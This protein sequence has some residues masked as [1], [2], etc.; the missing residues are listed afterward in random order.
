LLLLAVAALTL[1][2]I[3]SAIDY[4]PNVIL[5]LADDLGYGDIG[6]YGNTKYR[7]PN[8]DRLAQDGTKFT[9]FYVAQAVCTASRAALMTGC[10]PNRVGMSGALN[11]T[12]RTGLNLDEALLCSLFSQRGYA[13]A[14]YGKWHLGHQP[15][16]LPTRRGFD[17]WQGLPYS[18]DNGPLHP[19]TR[20]IPSLPWY[21]NETVVELDPDQS[22]FTKRIT[23]I[24]LEFI[25]R[26]QDR[27]FF[28]YLPHIMPH[29]PI[30]ASA[31]FQ[32]KSPHG[33]YGDVIEELD[34]SIGKLADKLSELGLD[35]K[36]LVIFSS[37]NGPF[38]SYGEHA[39][40]A[41]PLRGGKLTTFE[42]GVRVPC[43]MRW[44]SQMPAGRVAEELVSTMDLCVS[45]T[46]WIESDVPKTM[47]D[48]ED[49]RPYLLG[50]SGSH[51]KRKFHYYSGEELHAVRV[52][53]WKLHVPHEYLEVTAEPGKAGKP[54]GFGTL[55]PQSIEQ[56]GIR[57]IASRHGYRVEP[58]EMS[59]YNL[60]ADVSEAK[61]LVTDFPD[62]VKELLIEIDVARR[63]LGDSLT[64]A[65]GGGLRPAGEF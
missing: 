41:G 42:G 46:K 54:S 62:I 49:L 32:G 31:E 51:G 29:V 65:Q 17:E 9:S 47:Q 59:L 58:M 57:G 3:A 2:T 20:G 63:D 7:T 4:R 10:Y 48:G 44:Q 24:A 45:L 60:D 11:H 50:E 30:F 37:D 34:W 5:I 27:P 16:F 28:L 25:D 38:L 35:E 53:P 19:V 39:G 43:I 52:G 40:T 6:C 13:T 1:S 21:K 61:N 23:D 64:Q 55:K 8:I 56:S 12:S 15:P 33:L 18:N 36:T 26:N 14:I 22:Q